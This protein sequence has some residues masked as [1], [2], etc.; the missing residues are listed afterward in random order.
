MD[1]SNY[2]QI[3]ESIY[4]ELMSSELSN[5]IGLHAGTSGVAL[6]IAYYDKIVNLKTSVNQR[7]MD[8][9]EYNIERINSGH[10]QHSICSG[11]SGFGWLCEHLRKLRMLKEED[12]EFLDDIDG[13]LYS[14]MIFDIKNGNYD[15]LHGALGVGAYFLSR[16]KKNKSPEFLK[17]LLEELEKTGIPCES[18]AIKWMSKLNVEGKKGYNISLSHGMSSIAAFLVCLHQ[19]KFETEKVEK[20]L[21][22]TI[23]YILHQMTYNENSISYFPSYSKE[24]NSRDHYSRL[25]WCYGDLGISYTLWRAALVLDNKEWEIIALRV[26]YHNCKRFDLQMNGVKDAGLCHG[27]AGISHIFWSLYQNTRIPEF[28]RASDYWLNITIQMFKNANGLAG[29]KVWRTE[30]LG[31][32][33]FSDFLLDG[34]SG[35]GLTFLSRMGRYILSWDECIMLNY[36]IED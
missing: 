21:V 27:S 1:Y 7:I 23:T 17:I 12:V 3:T 35:I 4:K 22:Q 20:L 15:Y 19:L 11:I 10:W 24:S 8:I 14:K 16:F 2:V 5:N 25:G 6:F 18:D 26:L 13:F 31:G 33:I 29:F 30:E 28:R 34:F 36:E 32:T 9:L